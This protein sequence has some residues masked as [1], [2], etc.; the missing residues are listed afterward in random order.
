MEAN[1]KG[2]GVGI[3][4]IPFELNNAG[5]GR[6]MNRGDAEDGR[7]RGSDSS[8]PLSHILMGEVR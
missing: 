1:Y 3:N 6:R 5:R 2:G 8:C 4:A 7:G